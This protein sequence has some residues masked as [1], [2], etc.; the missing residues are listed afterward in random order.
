M[1]KDIAVICITY[2]SYTLCHLGITN[3]CYFP[4]KIYGVLWLD[5]KSISFNSN[6]TN[7]A[8]RECLWC[9][10]HGQPEFWQE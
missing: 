10:H 8:P 1:H 4:V 3:Y 9:Y 7:N 5:N 6:A 2:Q